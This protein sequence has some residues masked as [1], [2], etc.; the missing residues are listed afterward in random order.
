MY[1]NPD[2]QA[3]LDSV[4][5]E[6]DGPDRVRVSGLMGLAPPSTTKVAIFA[7][8]GFQAEMVVLGTG[9]DVATKFKVFKEQ[10]EKNLGPERVKQFTTWSF[11]QCTVSQLYFHHPF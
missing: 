9:L 4:K 1:L 3:K 5:V 10:A 7:I 6:S 8:A 2:V 11:V